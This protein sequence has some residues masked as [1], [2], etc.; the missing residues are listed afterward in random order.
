M[1]FIEFSALRSY[2][3][4]YKILLPAINNNAMK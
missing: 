2:S 1:N 4:K 3:N